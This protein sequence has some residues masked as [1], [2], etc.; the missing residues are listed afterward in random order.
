M[1]LNELT[2]GQI[3]ELQCLFQPQQLMQTECKTINAEFINKKCI[4]RTYSAGVW[5]GLI[6]QKEGNEIIV[7]N[8]R[9]LWRWK[10]KKS[11]TLS[12]IATFGI[13][14][15]G[16]QF[17]PTVDSVWLEAIELIPCS[18]ISIKEIENEKDSN[19]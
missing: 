8:A 7:L 13:A 5:F 14:P 19:Q 3:K 9:R 12:A 6:S 15:T 1:N 10:A 2:L 18:N 16:N 11:I 17:T 4:I